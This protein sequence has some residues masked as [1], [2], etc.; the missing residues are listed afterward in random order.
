M[1]PDILA[2]EEGISQPVRDDLISRGHNVRPATAALGNAHALTIEYDEE[3]NP[4]RFNGGADP[5]GAGSAAG[6]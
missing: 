4:V 5:R 1:I 2:V 3:G 6:Y